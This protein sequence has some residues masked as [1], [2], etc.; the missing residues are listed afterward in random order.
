VTESSSETA[1]RIHQLT[2]RHIPEEGNLKMNVHNTKTL[3]CGVTFPLTDL[4]TISES[5]STS[6]S[7]SLSFTGV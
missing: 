6:A 4:G 3:F 2:G 5:I 1:V 7:L